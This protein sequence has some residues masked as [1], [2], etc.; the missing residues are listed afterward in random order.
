MKETDR[1]VFHGVQDNKN[2][3]KSIGKTILD[4]KRRETKKS[5][6]GLES[7]WETLLHFAQDGQ[8]KDSLRR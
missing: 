7:D 2:I 4:F 6:C 3:S 1:S 8:G 5:G